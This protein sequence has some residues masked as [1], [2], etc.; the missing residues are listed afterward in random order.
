MIKSFYLQVIKSRVLKKKNLLEG[1][2]LKDFS[3][4]FAKVGHYF[5]YPKILGAWIKKYGEESV[6]YVPY[7]NAKGYDCRSALAESLGLPQCEYIETPSLNHSIKAYTAFNCIQAAKNGISN[8][9]I[10]KIMNK[11]SRLEAKT[12]I[13]KEWPIDGYS[14]LNVRAY[15][16]D[17]NKEFILKN[18]RFGLAYDQ[19]TAT[20][21]TF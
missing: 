12:D 3:Q 21:K 1:E 18:K 16:Q 2:K 19:A 13:F 6:I 10:A 7:L 8:K 15:Y 5:C 20:V 11:L 14:E 17:I 9:D 4:F